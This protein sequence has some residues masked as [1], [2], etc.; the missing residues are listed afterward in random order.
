MKRLAPLLL[1]AA[2][3]PGPATAERGVGAFYDSSLLAW[4]DAVVQSLLPR[5]EGASALSLELSAEAEL[6]ERKARR[7][8]GERLRLRLLDEDVAVIPR[9]DGAPHLSLA[10]SLMGGEAWAVGLLR[11]G[12]AIDGA[13]AVSWPIDRELEA[14]L[15]APNAR[16][17]QGRWALERLGTVPSG[18]LDL[19]LLDLDSRAGDEVALLTVD[20]LR[21]LR[22]DEGAARP[23]PLGGPWALGS[24][25]HGRFAAGWLAVEGGAL[26]GA[27]T[28]WSPV[29]ID[30]QTGSLSPIDGPLRLRQPRDP[31][32][33]DALAADGIEGPDLRLRRPEGPLADVLAAAPDRLRDLQ[34]WPGHAAAV[35]VGADGRIGGV[36][37]GGAP[38]Q[39]PV[40]QAGD[41]IVLGDLDADG[42]VDL[43]VT[44]ASAPGDPDR[45]SV[46]RLDE[47]GSPLLFQAALEGSVVAL[48]LGDLD[49]DGQPDL[50]L[51][52][53]GDGAEAVLWR[54][55]RRR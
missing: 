18:V 50:V 26:I 15:V 33:P 40:G 51:V 25:A 16:L 28:A 43:A 21:T 29:G 32:H 38:L 37:P 27:T 35:W 48:G 52:E 36:R 9:S 12:P 7:V 8:F 3:L 49:F 22:F 17:G 10:L 6:D 42:R 14:L 55:E 41:R 11:G 2:L 1:L 19:A 39:P 46:F 4:V 53:E 5:L 45:L 20:G 54:L 13:L 47:D 31:A 34:L 44:E 24:A 30:A 23:V